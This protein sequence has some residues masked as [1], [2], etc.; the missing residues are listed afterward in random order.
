MH[1]ILKKLTVFFYRSCLRVNYLEIR[2]LKNT[3][4]RNWKI[5]SQDKDKFWN[6]LHQMFPYPRDSK[7]DNIFPWTNF[8]KYRHPLKTV[9]RKKYRHFW[10]NA[11]TPIYKG[12]N[13]LYCQTTHL[14]SIAKRF[15]PSFCPSRF[16]KN[17]IISRKHLDNNLDEIFL[18]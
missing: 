6:V 1:S 12:R 3:V 18:R 5:A 13:D 14:P 11:V 2:S 9:N 8:K 15:R 10:K 7:D 17:T 4:I 16:A